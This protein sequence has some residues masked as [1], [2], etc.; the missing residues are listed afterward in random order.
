MSRSK[1]SPLEWFFK[2]SRRGC[3]IIFPPSL[4]SD[5]VIPV[6]VHVGTIFPFLLFF[7]CWF[8]YVLLLCVESVCVRWPRFLEEG[9]LFNFCF[10]C[11]DF[12]TKE[13]Y[14]RVPLRSD[15]EFTQVWQNRRPTDFTKLLTLLYKL[16]IKYEWIWSLKCWDFL[17]PCTTQFYTLPNFFTLTICWCLMAGLIIRTSVTFVINVLFYK[18]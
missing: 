15:E 13:D 2:K 6:P 17:L 16:L 5:E 1:K 11:F 3:P 7:L 12:D 14:Y 18:R 4:V 10:K 9:K 8:F